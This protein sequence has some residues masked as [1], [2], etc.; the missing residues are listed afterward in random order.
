MQ[1]KKHNNNKDYYYYAFSS[2]TFNTKQERGEEIWRYNTL[3]CSEIEL[4][5]G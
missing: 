4:Q 5:R 1:N 3:D 2:Y